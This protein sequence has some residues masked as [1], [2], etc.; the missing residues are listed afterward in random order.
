[1]HAPDHYKLYLRSCILFV[2]MTDIV[3]FNCMLRFSFCVKAVCPHSYTASDLGCVWL[4]SFCLA[5]LK[6]NKRVFQRT[7]APHRLLSETDTQWKV[8]MS[9]WKSCSKHGHVLF[10]KHLLYLFLP[11]SLISQVSLLHR[12][13]EQDEWGGT[14]HW[15]RGRLFSGSFP[16]ASVWRL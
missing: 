11:T 4:H 14:S 1:M 7:Q 3:H 15:D 2:L 8:V 5:L 16:P 12:L 9:S 10:Y 6:K 13:E